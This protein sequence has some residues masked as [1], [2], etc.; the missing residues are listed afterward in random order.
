[1]GLGDRTAA[2]EALAA[3]REAVKAEDY[4]DFAVGQHVMTSDGLPGVVASVFDGPVPG[5]ESYWVVL[6]KAMGAGDYGASQLRPIEGTTASEHHQASDDY[7]EL[8]DIYA[9]LDPAK[10][11]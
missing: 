1:M 6:A 3:R 10:G 2:Q 8:A 7:P 5:W 11:I 4:H 9:H